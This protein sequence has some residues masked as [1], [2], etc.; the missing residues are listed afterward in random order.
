MHVFVN[1]SLTSSDPIDIEAW[2]I[3]PATGDLG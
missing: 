1:G 2:I 3:F